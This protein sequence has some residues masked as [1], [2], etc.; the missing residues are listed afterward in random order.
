MFHGKTHQLWKVPRWITESPFFPRQGERELMCS[1]GSDIRMTTSSSPE[2]IDIL[3]SAFVYKDLWGPTHVDQ[4]ISTWFAWWWCQI[5]FMFTPTLTNI[6]QRGWNHSLVCLFIVSIGNLIFRDF[7]W[8][9]PYF[10]L[11]S[12]WSAGQLVV[13]DSN[14]GIPK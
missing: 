12:N 13:W 9:L 4:H 1:T 11:S 2:C 6:F 8:W 14:R 5:V 3:I 10:F 7:V